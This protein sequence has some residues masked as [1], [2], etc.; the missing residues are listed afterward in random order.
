MVAMVY[1]PEAYRAFLDITGVITLPQE[2]FTRPELVDKIMSIAQSEPPLQ[3]PGPSR[4]E[5]MQLVA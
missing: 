3:A 1:D 4:E 5:L 2:V